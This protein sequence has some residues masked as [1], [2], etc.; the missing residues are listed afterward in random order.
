MPNFL[1]FYLFANLT[2][3]TIAKNASARSFV[4]RVRPAAVKA[5][6]LRWFFGNALVA[7]LAYPCLARKFSH[8]L[9]LARP[10]K[11]S[12]TL[13]TSPR[14]VAV[15]RSAPGTADLKLHVVPA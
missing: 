2:K 15:I 11:H 13:D 9:A 12:R 3:A 1:H 4:D 8:R 5:V 14:I 10:T 6:R 7:L